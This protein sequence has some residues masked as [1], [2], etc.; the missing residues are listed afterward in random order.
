MA[1]GRAGS[2]END[3]GQGLDGLAAGH[4]QSRAEVVPEC[5]FELGAGLGEGEEAREI[6]RAFATRH[7][8]GATWVAWQ[9]QFNADLDM[10]TD[11]LLNRFAPTTFTPAD[12]AGAAN[13]PDLTLTRSEIDRL[14]GD[15]LAWPDFSSHFN[16]QDPDYDIESVALEYRSAGLVRP[17]L[18]RDLV[19]VPTGAALKA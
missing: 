5:D 6:E 3:F 2:G 8:Y 13:W 1:S 16:I 7:H 10:A 11:V 14:A 4:G 18:S 9:A 19:L 15:F 17:W 12:L